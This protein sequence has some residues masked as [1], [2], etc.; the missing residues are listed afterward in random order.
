MI[1]NFMEHLKGSRLKGVKYKLPKQKSMREE[2][3]EMMKEF[4]IK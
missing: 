2:M 3:D 1:N 4:N